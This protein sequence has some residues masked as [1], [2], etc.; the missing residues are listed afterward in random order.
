MFCVTA[1]P[2]L[3]FVLLFCCKGHETHDPPPQKSLPPHSQERHGLFICI[4]PTNSYSLRL[5]SKR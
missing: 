4:T 3:S 5:W 1:F 2:S